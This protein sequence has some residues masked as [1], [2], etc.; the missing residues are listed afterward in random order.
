MIL[1]ADVTVNEGNDAVFT[2]SPFTSATLPVLQIRPDSESTFENIEASDPRLSLEDS[3]D[4]RT[5][6]Y[7]D[8]QRD[9]DGTQFT[10]SV[11][12]ILANNPVTITVYCKFISE[13]R[14]SHTL[15]N[16]IQA[17]NCFGCTCF[18][19]FRNYHRLYTQIM[20]ACHQLFTYHGESEHRLVLFA[21]NRKHRL[22]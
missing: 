8:L 14:G 15:H 9:E 1:P 11:N 10:C 12:G 2:C 18:A 6:T 16:Y 5:Y 4:G 7:S 3:V 17:N 19:M 22:D 13:C 20:T 21:G